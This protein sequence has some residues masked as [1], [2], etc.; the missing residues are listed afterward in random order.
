MF[1]YS[2]FGYVAE[3]GNI[4][5]PLCG[6][7]LEWGCWSWLAALAGFTCL[8]PLHNT[9]HRMGS[10]AEWVQE[11][12]WVPVDVRRTKTL[13]RPCG[14]IWGGVHMDP[15]APTCVCYSVLFSLYHLGWL[16]CE[17]AQWALCL[18][19]E[20]VAL[21]Q[22]AQRVSQCDILYRLHPWSPSSCLVSRKNKVAGT[23][24]KTVNAGDFIADGSGFKWK[25]NGV[26]R[27]SFPEV[28][29][30]SARLFSKVPLSNSLCFSSPLLCSPPLKPRVF[31]STGW[32]EGRSRGCFGK[33]NIQTEKQRCKVLTFGCGSRLEAGALTRDPALFCLEFLC[34]LS[35]SLLSPCTLANPS[36]PNF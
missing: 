18:S 4:H 28:Q 22:R 20:A 29:W 9:S 11:P 16:Q 36:K 7:E 8:D 1:S 35:L 21:H 34:L 6:R 24:W 2:C 5:W 10:T 33:G 15:K 12:G 25:R 30:S 31:M 13:C 26:G 23:N 19:H 32:G 3:T 14:S 17:T 27:D